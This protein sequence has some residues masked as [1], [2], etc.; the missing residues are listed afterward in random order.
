LTFTHENEDEIVRLA[1]GAL[2]RKYWLI[3]KSV[4]LAIGGFLGALVAFGVVSYQSAVSAITN[5]GV[6]VAIK[7]IEDADKLLNT[8]EKLAELNRLHDAVESLAVCADEIAAASAAGLWDI[9]SEQRAKASNSLKDTRKRIASIQSD[10]R[11][12]YLRRASDP[13][14]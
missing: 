6:S 13:R 3:P 10:T 9:S 14:T 1:T 8:P 4:P 11:V 12:K 7:R 2:R 5:T